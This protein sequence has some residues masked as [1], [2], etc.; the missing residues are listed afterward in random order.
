MVE[1]K[2]EAKG[3]AKDGNSLDLSAYAGHWVAV[4]RGRVTA[5]GETAREA[6]L[7]ARYQCL[8]DDPS[9]IWVPTENLKVTQK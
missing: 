9:L 8:K 5:V 6:L 4:A 7:A 1:R 2:P 3:T